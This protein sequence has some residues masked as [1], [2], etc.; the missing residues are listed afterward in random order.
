MNGEGVLHFSTSL[1]FSLPTTPPSLIF[2]YTLQ[3]G[4]RLAFDSL[5]KKKPFLF[6][7]FHLK[8]EG[9]EE[10]YRLKERCNDSCPVF[11]TQKSESLFTQR[12]DVPA[13]VQ[14]CGVYVF[15][16]NLLCS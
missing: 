1:L 13:G 16:I 15:F 5:T 12:Y 11:F 3:G 4:L 14:G 7:L 6:R 2:P 9:K 8:A 10:E